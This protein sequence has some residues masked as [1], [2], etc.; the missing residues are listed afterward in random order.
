MPLVALLGI[1]ASFG[2]LSRDVSAMA[3]DPDITRELGIE[4]FHPPSV[5][6]FG[7]AF[8]ASTVINAVMCSR[9]R[10]GVSRNIFVLFAVL[11]IVGVAWVAV[12]FVSPTF[13]L[14]EPVL[15]I[16]I[17]VLCTLITIKLDR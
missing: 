6:F 17:A 2:L 10:E 8:L 9:L 15:A 11:A 4:L 14:L 5:F 1:F 7:L 16:T 13:L 12:L 3:P